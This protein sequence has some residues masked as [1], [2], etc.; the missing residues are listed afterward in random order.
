MAVHS[1]HAHPDPHA[2]DRSVFKLTIGAL[3]VVF[4]DIGTS[5]LYAI[6][7]SF[8]P[9]HGLVLTPDNVLGILSLVFWSLTLVIVLKYS[10]FILR[11]DKGGEGGIT[12]LLALLLPKFTEQKNT[13]LRFLVIVLG[14]FGTG[15]LL[16]EG[17]ITPAISVL[18]AIEGLEVATPAFQPFIVPLTIIILL[19]LFSVQKRGTGLIGAIFGPT[20]LIWFLTLAG[21]GIP[22]ILRRPEILNAVNPLYAVQFFAEHGWR[23][24]FILGSVVLCITGAE[25]LYADM[26][27]FGKKPIRAGW[28]FVV[29]PALLLNYFG[30][31]AVILER[32]EAALGNT[33][34]ALVS[35]WWIYP[36][37]FISTAATVIA[38]QALISGAFSIAFQSVQLGFL[39]R[40]AIQYTSREQEGQIYV[41]KINLF[42]MVS[43]IALVIAFGSSTRLAAAYGIAV[44]GTMT[45]TSILFFLVARHVWKWPLVPV[46]LL[47]LV[48]LITDISFFS[49]NLVKLAAGGWIP[50]LIAICVL[51][52]MTTWKRGRTSVADRMRTSAVGLDVFFKKLDES[53]PPRAK[54]T[55]VFMT[56]TKDIAPSVLLHH[57]KHNQILH[58]QVLLVSVITEHEPEIPMM[59]RVR[60][61]DLEHGFVKVIARYGY[62]ENPRMDEILSRCEASGLR[63]ERK[64]ISYFLGRESFVTTGDSGMALWRKKLFVFMSR[65]ARS[66][67]EYFSLPADQVIE[68]GS[69][70][71]I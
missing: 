8:H 31:G 62:M 56:L 53:P 15:L 14:V 6:R 23:G 9:E 52:I 46:S 50:V 2:H 71:K 18:S 69:Q 42:L 21:I 39:P 40:T 13:A 63:I 1:S 65:N 38:S 49:A 7:E 29:F 47:V 33:F 44:T 35:G 28:Y 60:V 55:A 43:C 16:G 51:S 17:V 32:G 24:F 19:I 54:G 3:G 25:A 70:I 36:L 27:H 34:F 22:W 48:F 45:I 12:A 10:S 68:I 66:A 20:T 30:Q 67:A 37:V 41:P 59:E 4:G 58:E 26:G 61:T 11:A 5:P 64:R 57:F